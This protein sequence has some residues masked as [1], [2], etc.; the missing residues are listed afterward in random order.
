VRIET[1]PRLVRDAK[2]E[3]TG[4]NLL[5]GRRVRG[6]T[7]RLRQHVTFV[8][9]GGELVARTTRPRFFGDESLRWRLTDLRL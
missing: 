3:W 9:E 8:Q 6:G 5:T 2:V 1:A 4:R 7:K